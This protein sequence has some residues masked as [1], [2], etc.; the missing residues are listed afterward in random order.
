MLSQDE[1][2]AEQHDSTE[3]QFQKISVE[4]GINS[5]ECKLRLNQLQ[6]QSSDSQ[7]DTL[8]K[9]TLVQE[10]NKMLNSTQQRI[11]LE[12]GEIFQ[13]STF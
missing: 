7:N 6:R 3:H 13:K 9:T 5:M 12:T 4:E 10:D 8:M 11:E 2:S 1:Q